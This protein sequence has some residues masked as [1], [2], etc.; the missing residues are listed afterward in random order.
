LDYQVAVRL[1]SLNNTYTAGY[2]G[3][4]PD[5]WTAPTAA[6]SKASIVTSAAAP[7]INTGTWKRY[8]A[9]P[10]NGTAI[11]LKGTV[12]D[13]RCVMH[14]QKFVGGVWVETYVP[15]DMA[16]VPGV[17]WTGYPV[18]PNTEIGL[19]IPCRVRLERGAEVTAWSNEF[20]VVCKVTLLGPGITEFWDASSTTNASAPRK[21]EAW[22]RYTSSNPIQWMEQETGALLTPAGGSAAPGGI[23][24]STNTGTGGMHIQSRVGITVDGVTDWGPWSGYDG[25]TITPG[26]GQPPAPVASQFNTPQ[27]NFNEQAY[28][29]RTLPREFTVQSSFFTLQIMA[30]PE[31]NN[32]VYETVAKIFTTPGTRFPTFMGNTGPFTS[33]FAFHFATNRRRSSVITI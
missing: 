13:Q 18:V 32:G 2:E 30:N 28:P 23:F 27:G 19:T 12:V 31:F 8:T 7:V 21:L 6:G 16:V 11:E 14:F 1:R 9:S 3:A 4:T 5:D 33:A 20:S 10:T 17:T 29:N 25:L 15:I 26:N 22:Y 24:T